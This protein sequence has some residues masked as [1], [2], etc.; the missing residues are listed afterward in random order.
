[1]N[2]SILGVLT[3][4]LV[5]NPFYEVV[6][7]SETLPYSLW[8]LFSAILGVITFLVTGKDNSSR[9]VDRTFAILLITAVLISPVGWI[10]YLFLPLGPLTGLVIAWWHQPGQRIP[11]KERYY[12]NMR[13]LFFLGTIPIFLFP[14]LWSTVFQPDPLATLTIGSAYFWGTLL[15]WFGLFIDSAL[16]NPKFSFAQKPFALN[17]AKMVGHREHQEELKVRT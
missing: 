12:Q 2:A 14:L 9:S 7:N 4:T 5:E 16:D 10:Y 15:L 11:W 3:R 13:N 8:V 17:P 1:M 6:V